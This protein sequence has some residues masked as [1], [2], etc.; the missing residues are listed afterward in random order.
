MD[1]RLPTIGGIGLRMR[2]D[3]VARLQQDGASQSWIVKDPVALRYFTFTAQEFAILKWLDGTRSLEE[4]RRDFESAFPPHR[5]TLQ[6]LQSFAARLH[7][8]GLLVAEGLDQGHILLESDTRQRRRERWQAWLSWLAIRFRGVDPER[9]LSWLYP[10]VRWCYSRW[11]LAACLLL[12]VA[13]GTLVAVNATEFRRQL[14]ALH[15]I[16]SP[17][18]VLWLLAAFAGAKVIHELGHALTC[19]HYGGECHEMGLIMLVFAPSLYCNVTDSW[20]LQNR[21]QRIA[22]SAAGI[23]VEIQLAAMAVLVWWNTQ[24]GIVHNIALNIVVVCSVGTILFNGNPLLRYDGYFVLSDLLRMPNLWQESRNAVKTHLARWFLRGQPIVRP[25]PGERR[26]LLTA[27][28][29]A[30]AAYRVVIVLAILLF[31]HRVLAPRGLGVLVPIVAAC[32]ALTA[33]VVWARALT[34]FWSRPMAWRQFKPGRVASAALAAAVCLGAFLLVPLPCR[35]RAPGVLEPAGAHRIYVATP[36]TL[37]FTAAAG[38]RINAG[39]VVARL[40]D[41]ILRR[42]VL[43]LSGEEKVAQIRVQNLQAR[44]ADEPDA[45]AQLQV[46]EEMLADV[47]E[48][49]RQRKQDEK[50]LTLIAPRAGQVMEP[51]DVP[52]KYADEQNLPMWMGSPLEPENSH[53]YL[54]RGTLF[55]MVGDPAKQEA[56]LFVDETDVQ[57]VRLG[58]PVRLQLTMHPA[59]VLTGTVIEIAERNIAS[60]PR[61]L[62]A[63]EELASRVD[64]SG[65]RRPVRTTYSIR[66]TLDDHDIHVLNGARGRAKIAVDPQP[67]AQRALR[68]LRRTLTV[69]L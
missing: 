32:L 62:V 34:R 3:L 30:S 36:G 47:R 54:E 53:C 31:L 67:L 12:V 50:A 33:A 37:E 28:G 29:L 20:M 8:N 57:Y 66:V 18:N 21:W 59:E 35:V 5:I 7:E 49:L 26:A 25:A 17:G 42:E 13:A 2:P 63:D 64:D 43:R 68:A 41:E 46:A 55:C 22:V 48:Q 10:K 6:H 39:D 51:P 65:A 52:S 15:E 61:E 38:Q 19:K 11:F 14:P 58:Q 1:K 60:V 4:L 44:L 40:E 27:Y 24:P 56:M 45:A 9:F 23:L 69:E 16:V